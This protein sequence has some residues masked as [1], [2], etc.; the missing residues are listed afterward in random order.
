MPISSSLCNTPSHEQQWF[1]WYFIICIAIHI[2]LKPVPYHRNVMALWCLEMA[3]IHITSS[4]QYYVY[5]IQQYYVFP[6]SDLS[7]Q[8]VSRYWQGN[9][10]K[11]SNNNRIVPFNSFCVS[12]YMSYLSS[13]NGEISFSLSSISS[14]GTCTLRKWA[15]CRC[16]QAASNAVPAWVSVSQCLFS[17]TQLISSPLSFFSIL[18]FFV[19][20][21]QMHRGFS[22]MLSVEAKTIYS[23]L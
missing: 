21:N 11:S 14:I 5:S 17:V 3:C 20:T 10:N 8:H 13:V 12:S 15:F 18:M 23:W 4:C 16:N 6:L 19:R 22:N 9:E 7:I 2:W 1:V